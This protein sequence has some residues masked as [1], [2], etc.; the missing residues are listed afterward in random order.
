MSEERARKSW[1]LDRLAQLVQGE[2]EGEGTTEIKGM[3][4]IHDARPGDITFLANPKYLAALSK[5]KAS[6]VIL[7]SDTPSPIPAIRTANPYLAFA[8]VAT[9]IH[10]KPFEP[11]GVSPDLVKGA[12]CRLGQD[13]SIHPRVT[14]GIGVEIGDRVTLYPG[15][16]IGDNSRVG[17]DS[18][19]HASVSIREGVRIGKRVIVHCG[20][21]IGSDGF[22]FAPDGTRYYKIPQTGGVEIGDDVE[23]GANTTIDRGAM[24]NTVI[25]RGTKIDNLVMIA[26]NVVIGE[27]VIIVSQVGISGSTR[28]GD[29]VTMGGQVG[30]AGHLEIGNDVRIGGQSGV[31]KNVAPGRTVSG[32]PVI[33]HR[34]W[35]KAASSFEHLPQI[36]K[37]VNEL[38]ARTDR[39]K[40]DQGGGKNK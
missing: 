24:G 38:S 39:K 4:S 27:D 17:D 34:K 30:V 5:T 2:V 23:I 16:F 19:V 32:F 8:R 29:H 1:R 37:K 35:L 10:R 9:E 7:P 13:L 33:D 21:V 31:T 22:G 20:V 15:V 28:I 40:I 12:G 11:H 25:G 14:L 36:R 26:H 6:A 3:A 18:I